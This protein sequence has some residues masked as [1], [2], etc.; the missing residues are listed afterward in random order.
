MITGDHAITAAAIARQIGLIGET[1]EPGQPLALNGRDIAALTD[2]ELVAAV[3]HCAVFARVAPEQKLRLVEALQA[4]GNIVAMTGDGVNDAPAL[5][6]A[7]IGVAMGI[8]G[9][10]VARESADMVLTDD[11][12]SSIEAAVEEGRGVYDNLVKFITWTLPTNLGEGLVIMAAVF[13]GAHLPIMPVQILWINMTTAV[14]LGLMLA[15]EPKEPGIMKRPPMDPR[16]PLLTRELMM[17]IG[18]VGFLLLVGAFGIF[19]WELQQGSSMAAAR[20]C[21]VNVFVFGEMFY[22][23]NCRSLRHSPFKLGLFSNRWLLAGVSLMILLQLL[24][25]YLPAMNTAF[26]SEPISLQEWGM[27]ISASFIVYIVIEFEKWIR[28]RISVAKE[29][30]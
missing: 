14:L 25:T 13:A 24:F 8:T 3:E 15:F 28:R 29:E 10:E 11:N 26:G 2:T 18:I 6:Q 5:R 21:A 1:G 30:S 9:T 20:T 19:E 17:R 12:F 23:F 16:Q 22:L 4:S 27:I 7:N